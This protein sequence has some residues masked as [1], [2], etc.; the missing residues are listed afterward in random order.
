MVSALIVKRRATVSRPD[1]APETSSSP[2]AALPSTRVAT[3]TP[4]ESTNPLTSTL[5]P[6]ERPVM[7]A[8][9]TA[10]EHR[11]ASEANRLSE[12]DERV[13]LYI[14]GLDRPFDIVVETDRARRAA[15]AIIADRALYEDDL[16]DSSCDSVAVEPS[17]RI[18][19]PEVENSTPST[20]MLPKPVI[21]PRA[22]PP[23]LIPPTDGPDG[24][25]PVPPPQDATS[26]TIAMTTPRRCRTTTFW[27]SL[28]MAWSLG[29][30]RSECGKCQ[31]RV[32]AAA[33]PPTLRLL[34]RVS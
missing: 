22:N 24:E 3:M 21:A 5:T 15:S 16:A 29:T 10:I 28:F 17:I 6:G 18:D 13:G 31:R 27:I 8:G 4:V 34:F 9:E 26:N 12:H 19:A 23:P 2:A 14:H 30:Y 1:S 25:S 32:A 7:S 20:K 33:L 11:R